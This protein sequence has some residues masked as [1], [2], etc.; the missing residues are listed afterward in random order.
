MKSVAIVGVGRMGQRHISAAAK[1]GLNL[2]AICDQ[3]NDALN[4]VGVALSL[5]ADAMFT[6]AETMLKSIKPE[7][8]IIATTADSHCPLTIMAAEHGVKH[9]LV[10]K[11]MAVSLMQCEQMIAVCEAHG[12]RLSINHQMRYLEQYIQPKALLKTSTFGGFKSMTVVGGNMGLAMNGTHYFEAF[13]FLSEE[14]PVAVNA[15][16][17]DSAA[18]NPRGPQFFDRAGCVRVTTASGKRLYMDICADQGH[19]LSVVYAGRNG[20]VSVNELTGE[21]IISARQSQYLDL[22]TTRYGM[23]A[24]YQTI[25]IK[26]LDI[27][28]STAMVLRSLLFDEN[29]VSAVEAFMTIKVLVAANLSAEDNGRTVRLDGPLDKNRIFPWA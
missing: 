6:D 1:L 19:G 13:R 15:W 4:A 27:V 9:I 28:D 26:E 14:M 2:V 25:E 17:E 12:A 3:S 24:D 16:L 18:P 22:P 5:G 7:V 23:P 11:P 8:L 20:L 10:E 29:F 21:L